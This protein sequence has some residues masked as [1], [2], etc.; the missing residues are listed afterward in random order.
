MALEWS[1]V[2]MLEGKGLFAPGIRVLDI[3]SSNVYCANAGGIAAFIGGR[4]PSAG[5]NA[6][7]LAADIAARSN[8]T[9]DGQ[10]QNKAFFGEVLTAAGLGYESV[11]IAKGYRTTVLDLNH[12]PMPEAMVNCFDLVMNVGTSE[13]VLNQ[14]AVFAFAHEATRPGGLMFHQLP[15]S[16]F[17]NHGYFCYTPRLFCDLAG[18]NDYEIVDLWFDGPSAQNNLLGALTAYRH[19]HPALQNALARAADSERDRIVEQTMVPDMS[20]NV[21]MRRTSAM[22]F[23]GALETST[24]VGRISPLAWNAYS[25]SPTQLF[26]R[27][28]RTAVAKRFPELVR[29]ARTWRSRDR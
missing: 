19:I 22:R 27:R 15:A 18:Y 17:A 24:S 16:G 23:L 12:D 10:Q 25:S 7:R 1:T 2:E 28:T 4:I 11:D 26:L 20:I 29:R 21:L 14:A 13:H 3:G 6:D 5:D 9:V 8:L